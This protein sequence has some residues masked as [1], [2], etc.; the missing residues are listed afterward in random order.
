MR[1]HPQS[2][3]E[4]KEML[5]EIGVSNIEELFSSIP[6]E[7]RS[8]IKCEFQKGLSEQETLDNFYRRALKNKSLLCVPS[9]LGAGASNHYVPLVID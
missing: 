2:P 9:F 3:E 7:I 6:K 5:G 8:E 1:Y 4:V